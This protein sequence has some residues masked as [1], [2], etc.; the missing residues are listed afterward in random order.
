MTDQTELL[1]G[2]SPSEESRNNNNNNNK[3]VE[4]KKVERGFG[5]YPR[6]Q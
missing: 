2:A 4:K 1:Q 3:E 5:R 6:Q